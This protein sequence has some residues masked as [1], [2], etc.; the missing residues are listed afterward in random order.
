M[1]ADIHPAYKEVTIVMTDGTSYKTRTTVGQEGETINLEIDR[2]S[3]PAYTKSGKQQ[4]RGGGQVDR[5]NKRF[6]KIS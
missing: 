4:V 5:F 2:T 1:K 6:K 3:H